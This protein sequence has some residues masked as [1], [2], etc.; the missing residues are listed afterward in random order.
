MTSVCCPGF[1][2]EDDCKVNFQFGFKANSSSLPDIRPLS[3]RD[4]ACL[5]DCVVDPALMLALLESV[6][7]R[8]VKGELSPSPL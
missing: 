4:A 3:P 8:Y 7:P 2:A 1:R 6:L 5:R